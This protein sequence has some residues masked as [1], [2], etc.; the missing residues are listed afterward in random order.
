M[1]RAAGTRL[2]ASYVNFYMANGGIVLP[3]F[4]DAVHDAAA[5]RTLQ[6]C[7]LLLCV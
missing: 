7:S 1:G 5:V 3:A 6:V 2:A 4:G